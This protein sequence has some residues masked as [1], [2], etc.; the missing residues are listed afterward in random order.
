MTAPAGPARAQARALR[1]R[2]HYVSRTRSGPPRVRAAAALD[3]L[4]QE[5]AHHQPAVAARVADRAVGFLVD[6]T[7]RLA[8]GEFVDNYSR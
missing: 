2:E 3:Y 4:R 8:R 7:D 1:R 6:L 5:M